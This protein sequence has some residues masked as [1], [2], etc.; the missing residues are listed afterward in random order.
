MVRAAIVVSLDK[1]STAALGGRAV[2]VNDWESAEAVSSLADSG[3]QGT[4]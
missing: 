1:A 2:L 3:V 4:G